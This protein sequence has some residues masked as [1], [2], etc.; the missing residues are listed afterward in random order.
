MQYPR[1][2]DAHTM[3]G[4]LKQLEEE[5]PML[6]IVWKEEN[7]EIGV[8]LMGE[9]QIEILRSL[10]EE[11][12]GIAVTF[13]AGSIVYKETIRNTVEGVGHYEPLRHYSEVHLIME[14]GEPGR[15]WCVTRSAVKISWIR[16][17][18]D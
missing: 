8:Q 16:T 2:V 4:Y 17:G 15:V 14:P 10:I 9:I 5:D 18:R 13:D 3:L 7:G 11:R 12:F 6:R 1:E